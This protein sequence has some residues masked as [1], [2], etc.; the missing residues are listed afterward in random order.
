M[1]KMHQNT[2][3]CQALPGPAGGA[4]ALPQPPSRNQ[5]VP[6]S[7]GRERKE[8]KEACLACITPRSATVFKQYVNWQVL[9]TRVRPDMNP[10]TSTSR[11]DLDCAIWSQ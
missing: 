10:D 5:G 9:R 6:T 8:G 1:P 11:R 3:G 2:F 7:K 4:L